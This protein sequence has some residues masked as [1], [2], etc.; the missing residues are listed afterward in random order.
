MKLVAPATVVVPGRASP[1]V[2]RITNDRHEHAAFAVSTIGLADEWVDPPLVTD[3]IAPGETAEITI[4]VHLPA[5]FPSSS[6]LVGVVAE[7]V[8]GGQVLRADLVLEVGGRLG[9]QV[10]LT[11]RDLRGGDRGRFDVVLLND[12]PDPATVSLEGLAPESRLRVD[13]AEGPHEVPPGETMAVRGRLKGGR[14]LTGQPRRLPFVVRAGGSAPP[15]HLEGSFTQTPVLSSGVLRALAVL[16]VLAL[17]LGALGIGLSK[18]E[19][20]DD[21]DLATERTN[22]V[23]EDGDGS[24]D[25][26]G[27]DGGGDDAGEDGAGEDGGEDGSAATGTKI[28]GTVDAAEPGGVRVTVSPATMTDEDVVGASFVGGAEPGAGKRMGASVQVPGD[29]RSTVTDDTGQYALAGLRAPAFYLVTFSKAGYGSRSYVV[30]ATED[31]EPIALDVMLEAG[32]G[33]VSGVVVDEDGEPLGGAEVT[34]T[35]GTVTLAATTP[36]TGDGIGQ[37][38]IA[39]LTTPG[40]F[41]VSA[42]RSGYGTESTLVALEGSGSAG[43]LVLR[44][45]AGVGSLSGQVLGDG[46]PLGGVNVTISGEGISRTATTLTDDPIGTYLIPQLPIPGE[47]TVEVTGAGYA[48]STQRLTVDG[49]AV[50]DIELQATLGRVFGS[51]LDQD[52]APLAGVG[53]T[54]RS[55]TAS[56]KTTSVD[57]PMGAYELEGIPAGT[58]VATFER[59][60]YTPATQTIAVGPGGATQSDATLVELEDR[61]VVANS[62]ISGSVTSLTG[63]PV[64]TGEVELVGTPFGATITDG[65]FSIGS[66]PAGIYNIRVDVDRHEVGTAR[67]VL[68]QGSTATVELALTPWASANGIVRS[69]GQGGPVVAGASVTFTETQSGFE[70]ATTT[71]AGGTWSLDQALPAGTYRVV[72]SHADHIEATVPN[73]VVAPGAAVVLDQVLTFKQII[74]VEVRRDTDGAVLRG[75]D[76]V[77][78]DLFTGAEARRS[79]VTVPSDGSNNSGTVTFRGLD[80]GYYWLEV[81]AQGFLGQ[82]FLI[83]ARNND[84]LPLLFLLAPGAGVNGL[85]EWDDSGHAEGIADAEI[86]IS[87]IYDFDTAGGPVSA[88]RQVE[89][90][91]FGVFLIDDSDLPIQGNA[92]IT[93]THPD[94]VTL[95]LDPIDLR[96][97]GATPAAL[98]P[99]R[100]VPLP[101]TAS[102]E[103]TFA[104]GAPPDIDDLDITVVSQ[105]QGSAVDVTA[106]LDSGT[107]I[108]SLVLADDAVSATDEQVLP[109]RYELGFSFPGHV[110]ESV[111]FRVEPSDAGS[112]VVEL[113][114]LGSIAAQV[115]A[116]VNGV[117]PASYTLAVPGASVT[118]TRP[119]GSTVTEAASTSGDVTFDDLQ[120]GTYG[121][122]ALSPSHQPVD[123]NPATTAIDPMSVVV[124]PGDDLTSQVQMVAHASIV[125]RVRAQE[126]TGTID[127]DVPLTVAATFNPTT[128]NPRSWTGT[129]VAGAGGYSITGSADTS[130][131]G[132]PNETL[133]MSV[134]L[135]SGGAGVPGYDLP[136]SEASITTASRFGSCN[137][138]TDRCDLTLI[139]R[140]GAMRGR[141]VDGSG[142]VNGVVV[143]A[144]RSDGSDVRTETTTNCPNIQPFNNNDTGCYG[145][146]AD[147]ST[148]ANTFNDL[149][150]GTYSV[151]FRGS[152]YKL[153][154][155]TQIV[156][157]RGEINTIATQTLVSNITSL[158]VDVMAIYDPQSPSVALTAGA[159]VQLF[160]NGSAVSTIPAQTVNAQGQVTFNNLPGDQT[161]QI[162]AT[163]D[164]FSLGSGQ[165]PTVLTAGGT[166][167]R[168]VT[169]TALTRTVTITVRSSAEWASTNPNIGVRVPDVTVD[170][171]GVS[172]SR[173]DVLDLKADANGQVT[174]SLPP[175]DY[176]LDIDGG[177]ASPAH[178]DVANSAMT[179]PVTTSTTVS[180]SVT[181]PERRL[182]GTITV[183]DGEGPATTTN[184]EVDLNGT[185]ANDPSG[186][187]PLSGGAATFTMYVAADT[188]S[189]A[190]SVEGSTDHTTATQ[191]GIDLTAAG[192]PV[193]VSHT[194]VRLGDMRVEVRDESGQLVTGATVTLAATSPSRTGPTAAG[195]ITF[196]DL[197]PRSYTIN[198]TTTDGQSGQGN[199]TVV[200]GH[201]VPSGSVPDVTVVVRFPATTTTSTTT[202]S[203]T[204]STTPP[205]TVP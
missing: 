16:S 75:A 24:A 106:T 55:D 68:A 38:E 194:L 173:P 51:T 168:T 76:V 54:L 127:L 2:L 60:G 49:N 52:Q 110:D 81:S 201:P 203:T 14:P 150:H 69:G 5:G 74:E 4:Q 116:T 36:T 117:S 153:L 108:V 17:W 146:E 92:S 193:S 57:S 204:S 46:A 144:T 91:E 125:G 179:V 47:Y 45:F 42:T 9:L 118:L 34:V 167:E 180:R 44:M 154:E 97:A 23:D 1:V 151:T 162:R 87:G 191:T 195:L 181:I 160:Q 147:G 155:L 72:F 172:A 109:G 136:A 188:Y 170:I 177:T 131:I 159:S 124:G 22:Q 15:V 139:P 43:G 175:G 185:G 148:N 66:L 122:L 93:V 112:F 202:S 59:F 190:A 83:Y 90:D 78:Y 138:G 174:A 71:N 141:V 143:T 8:G 98:N 37:F 158:V 88:V 176:Q 163:A 189:L 89:T 39:G 29:R 196:N 132:L 18:L 103:L 10:D 20:K 184:V 48:D 73:L 102:G 145:Y 166:A 99:V 152:G 164:G 12:S 165:W 142:G 100:L 123:A 79:Q 95:E 137:N 13:L 86:S 25:G 27:A 115:R 35:D 11:P 182:T 3:A 70:A 169:L 157:S 128:G 205:T 156:V 186:S 53:V 126:G 50:L 40:S 183:N 33:T 30:E 171:E 82:G 19:D 63:D 85:V 119:D 133:Q 7:P 200:A 56:F 134:R 84:V 21:D 149:P 32:P 192:T 198:V 187:F 41:L 65:A 130:N 62:T 80:E 28:G 26:G 77:L 67:Q 120:P 107:G 114:G 129:D 96:A 58:Y 111:A 121:L 140:P 31:G 161:Y 199:F 64:T 94:F 6:H 197:V 178:L 135:A 101:G 113:E 105:P 104:P 61:G